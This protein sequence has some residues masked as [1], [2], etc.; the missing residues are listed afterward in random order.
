M[1]PLGSTEVLNASWNP[2]AKKFRVRFREKLPEGLAAGDWISSAKYLPKVEVKNCKFRGMLGRALVFSTDDVVVENCDI[3]ATAYTGM[4]LTSGARHERQGP[5]PRR[6]RIVNNRF[7]GTGGA[8]IFGY[9]VVP[10][11]TT[12]AMGEITISGNTISEDPELA[13]VRLKTRRPDWLHW[14]AGI[15]LTGAGGIR[16]EDNAFDGY[17]ISIFLERVSDVVL[18]DNRSAGPT[19]A[20]VNRR[21]GELTAA[22][23]QNFSLEYDKPSYDAEL[24]YIGIIR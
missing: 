22:D 20:V 17:P 12:E 14:S 6:V 10:E 5:S 4:L 18:K 9:I 24:R 15:C 11:P 3:E 1:R 2:G 19:V 8:A 16:I 13:K 7:H 23:N 21:S